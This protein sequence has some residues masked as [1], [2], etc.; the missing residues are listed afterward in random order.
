VSFAKNDEFRYNKFLCL[1]GTFC[2][3]RECSER[4]KSQ[5]ILVIDV[6]GLAVAAAL[7]AALWVAGLKVVPRFVRRAAPRNL[8]IDV[9]T[10]AVAHPAVT[11]LG[12]AAVVGLAVESGRPQISV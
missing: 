1:F 2:D 8:V 7:G 11:R 9:L 4:L 6:L 5:G 3:H 12:V 10:G